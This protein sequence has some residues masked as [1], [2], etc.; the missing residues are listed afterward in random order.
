MSLVPRHAIPVP[1]RLLV[2]FACLN[3]SEAS[4]ME[5]AIKKLAAVNKRKLVYKTGAAV[6]KLLFG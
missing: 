5:A 4:K 6:R 2:K 1:I 3:Q